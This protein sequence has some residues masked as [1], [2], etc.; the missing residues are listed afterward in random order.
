MALSVSHT[1]GHHDIS[2]VTNNRGVLRKA[3]KHIFYG[4]SK[5]GS[6]TGYHHETDPRSDANVV[7]KVKNIIKT[8]HLTI[9]IRGNRFN[10]YEAS[11]INRHTKRLKSSNYGKSTFFDKNL[12]RDKV[13]QLIYEASTNHLA[14]GLYRCSG[15]YSGLVLAMHFNKSNDLITAYPKVK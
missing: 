6:V 3:Q 8:K 1:S 2:H 7:G 9:K 15:K 13:L 4:E 5:N 11:V 12:S 14:S 10:V